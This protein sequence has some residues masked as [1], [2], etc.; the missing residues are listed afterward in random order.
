[1]NIRD[2]VNSKTRNSFIK[3]LT[4]NC[5]VVVSLDDFYDGVRIVDGYYPHA[6][7]LYKDNDDFS[8]TYN[9]MF[10]ALEGL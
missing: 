10:V 9:V 4:P 3:S 5:Q 8:L 7:F 2:H 1:M 6:K